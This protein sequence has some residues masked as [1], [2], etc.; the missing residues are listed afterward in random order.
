MNEA[1]LCVSDCKECENSKDLPEELA[2]A[3]SAVQ[4]SVEGFL[5]LLESLQHAG[6]EQQERFRKIREDAVV[7][8]RNVRT[9]LNDFKARN[10]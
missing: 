8:I 3:E 7:D 5:D 1:R 6:A 4:R 9:D 10:E 2:S